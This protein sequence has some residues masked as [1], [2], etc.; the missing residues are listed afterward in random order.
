MEHNPRHL[1]TEAVGKDSHLQPKL[2]EGKAAR[3]LV[4]DMSCSNAVLACNHMLFGLSKPAILCQPTSVMQTQVACLPWAAS[5]CIHEL[6]CTPASIQSTP[7]KF[8]LHLHCMAHCIV[9]TDRLVMNLLLF[10]YQFNFP[11]SFQFFFISFQKSKT[12]VAHWSDTAASWPGSTSLR[13]GQPT[14]NDLSLAQKRACRPCGI[15]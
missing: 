9:C 14:L 12:S 5:V 3:L 13:G 10:L 8:L 7:N 1:P 6:H 11:C 15:K 4:M 2:Y